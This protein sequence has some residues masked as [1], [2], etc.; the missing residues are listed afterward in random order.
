MTDE[1]KL[2]RVKENENIKRKEKRESEM[3]TVKKMILRE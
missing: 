3:S 2:I 1:P